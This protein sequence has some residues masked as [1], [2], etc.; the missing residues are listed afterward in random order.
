MEHF[1]IFHF[2]LHS[3]P[4]YLFVSSSRMTFNSEIYVHERTFSFDMSVKVGKFLKKNLENIEIL[5]VAVIIFE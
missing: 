2:S 1:R 3:F 5:S 4:F